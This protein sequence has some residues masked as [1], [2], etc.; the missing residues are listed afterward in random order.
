MSKKEIVWSVTQQMWGRRLLAQALELLTQALEFLAEV[1]SGML[2][3][4]LTVKQTLHLLNAQL[5]VASLLLPVSSH[6]LYYVV[7]LAWFVLALLGCRHA[8]ANLLHED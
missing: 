2:G 8:M 7:A 3:E 4:D 1:Y 5:A 6:P